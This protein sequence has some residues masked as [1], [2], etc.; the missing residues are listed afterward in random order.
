MKHTYISRFLFVAAVFFL[1]SIQSSFSQT[2]RKNDLIIK[3]DSSRIEALILEVDAQVVKYKKYSDQE[4]PT[5]SIEKTEIAS[6]IYGNGE[7]ETFN[8][9]SEIYFDEDPVPAVVPYKSKEPVKR[10]KRGTAQTLDRDQLK[11]NYNFY[12][13]KATKYRTMSIVGAS[14]GSLMTIS[15]IITINA[16]LRDDANGR[17]TNNNIEA[18]LVGGTFLILGG[19][20]AGIPLTIIG[21]VKKGSYNRKAASTLQELKRRGDPLS[22]ITIHPSF[23][24]VN[25]SGQL[26]LRMSF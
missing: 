15:G 19:L 12:L 21:L 5:F 2:N 18:R 6:I 20:G 11:F 10:L 25:G 3:R 24:P 4:G 16:A 7:I 26:G 23:N 17:Y 13:K 1:F 22:S 8:A 14:L 9:K